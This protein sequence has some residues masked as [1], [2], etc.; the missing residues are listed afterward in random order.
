MTDAI[1]S[2]EY[3]PIV[4]GLACNW[5]GYAAADQAG[6][7]KIQY[8]TNIKLARVM[9]LGTV[10]P[11]LMIKAFTRGF[12]GVILI[13]CHIGECHYVSGN[14][15]ALLVVERIKKILDIIGLQ[16]GRLKIEEVSAGE[17][18]KFARVVKEFIEELKALGPSPL[19]GREAKVG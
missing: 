7:A 8:P 3:E 15:N 10:D 2:K 6:M 1:I 12:D 19:R 17:A 14:K 5:C 16:G 11:H 13:G 9:C 18:P 4:L